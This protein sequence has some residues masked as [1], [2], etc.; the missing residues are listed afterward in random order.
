MKKLL[1]H[2]C[3]APCSPK[4]I[5]SFS[6]KYALEGFWCNPNI[7]PTD[8]YVLRKDALITL[9][10]SKNIP[11]HDGPTMAEGSWCAVAGPGKPRRCAFCYHLRLSATA[12]QARALG[13][14]F[15]STTLLASPYQDHDLVRDAGAR[16]ATGVGLT[17]VYEDFRPQFYAGKDEAK[18][19]GLY[20]QKYCGCI[21]S[22]EERLAGKKEKAAKR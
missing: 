2:H 6:G 7:H 20:V 11:L 15:F 1:L 19:A 16:A 3:C 8:E 12:A 17:F 14:S 4:V 10:T 22:R 18:K 21:F 5:E 9:L 13:F